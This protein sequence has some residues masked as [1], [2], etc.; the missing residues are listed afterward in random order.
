MTLLKHLWTGEKVNPEV[1]TAYQYVLDL[2]ERIEET[3][4]LA[5]KEIA[6]VQ[7]RNQT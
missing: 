7:K 5:Q 6:K 3:R 2:R 1:K 4:Q